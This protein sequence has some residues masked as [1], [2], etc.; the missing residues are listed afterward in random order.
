MVPRVAA[1]EAQ[2]RGRALGGSSDEL[3]RQ[4]HRVAQAETQH[5]AVEPQR[6]VIVMRGQYD[7][8]EALLAGDEPVPVWADDATVLQS[9][10]VKH[11]QAITGRILEVDHFVDPPVDFTGIAKSLGL[12]AMRITEAKDLPSTLSSAFRRPGAKLIEVV[13]DGSL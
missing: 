2:P 4:L 10:A 9:G 8:A 3:R 11:L 6:G 12:K 5:V 7:V 1:E 13:V